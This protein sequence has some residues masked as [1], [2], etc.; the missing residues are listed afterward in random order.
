MASRTILN[1]ITAITNWI[2][3]GQLQLHGAPIRPTVLQPAAGTKGDV[4]LIDPS[5]YVI[6]DRGLL[7]IS[8]SPHASASIFEQNQ[9]MWRISER[10][11]GQM[12]LNQPLT[13]PDG[14]GSPN[15]VSSVVA[16]N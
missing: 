10:I 15:T 14:A 8:A 1:S 16:L 5:L 7:E 9:L 12:L 4:I 11:D 13:I 2:P 6:G 3:N